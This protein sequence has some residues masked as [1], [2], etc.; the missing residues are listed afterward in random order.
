[1]T[2]LK[3]LKSKIKGYLDKKYTLRF[4]LV[5][6]VILLPITASACYG[7]GVA[8]TTKL[9]VSAASMMLDIEL[10]DWAFQMIVSR[11]PEVLWMI[12]EFSKRANMSACPDNDLSERC[13]YARVHLS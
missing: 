3:L 6:I 10:N 2:S 12:P 9:M 7:W 1:M 4:I 8:D 11:Y 13:E 5:L